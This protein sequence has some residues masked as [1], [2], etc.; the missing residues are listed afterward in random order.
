MQS[1]FVLNFAKYIEWPPSVQAPEFKIA[2]L[3]DAQA[4]KS[5]QE[6]INGKEVGNQRVNIY[7]IKSPAEATGYHLVFVPASQSGRLEE[8]LRI[9]DKKAT[10]VVSEKEGLAKKEATS[11]WWYWKVKC[12]LRSIKKPPNRNN[13]KWPPTYSSWVLWY[14]S[15]VF[16]ICVI[17]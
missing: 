3:G 11:I 1:L 9:I 15:V 4:F 14:S 6:L 10:L 16:L 7:Q 17:S 5:M 12:A 8:T 13:S 2:V